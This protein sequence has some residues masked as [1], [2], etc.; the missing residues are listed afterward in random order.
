MRLICFLLAACCSLSLADVIYLTNG[1]RLEGIVFGKNA[2][3]IKTEKG[4]HEIP[5]E[6]IDYI[7]L[8]NEFSSQTHLY[9][10][11]NLMLADRN[12]APIK[13]LFIPEAVSAYEKATGQSFEAFIARLWETG[14]GYLRS[15]ITT[16]RFGKE[17]RLA[18]SPAFLVRIP[19]SQTKESLENI[20]KALSAYALA[21]QGFYPKKLLELVPGYLMEIPKARMGKIWGGEDKNTVISDRTPQD[22]ITEKDVDGTSAWVYNNQLGEIALNYRGL[23]FIGTPWF[24]R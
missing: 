23:D 18:F 22:G 24:K 21:R 14:G 4:L 10:A 2:V 15:E 1:E 11:L 9:R 3:L 16:V 8:G 13:R 7:I 20:R 5:R 19:E 17:Y 12:T 6:E